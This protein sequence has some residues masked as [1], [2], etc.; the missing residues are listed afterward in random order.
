MSAA[1]FEQAPGAPFAR[2]VV[3]AP[4]V[5][6]ERLRSYRLG[7]LRA[8]MAEADVALCVLVNPVSLRYALDLREYAL[9][10]S[11]IPTIYAFVPVTGP[12]VLHGAAGRSYDTVDEYRTPRRLST[13]DGGL[14]LSDQAR[15]FAS[16]VK[17]L[18]REI[19]LGQ[20]RRVGVEMLNPSAGQALL[21]VG[22][23]TVDGESLVERARSIKAPEEIACQRH[24]IAVAEHAMS[25]MREALAPGIRETEL[26]SILHQVN[27]AHDGDWCDGRMLASGPRTNPWLQEASERVVRAGELVA[28]DTDMIGPL[29]YC[30]DISRT[31]LC[32]D[33]EATDIQRDRYRRARDEVEHNLALLRPGRSFRELSER[34]F[35]HPPEFVARRYPCLAHG[36]GM[37]DEWPKIHYREDWDRD[38]YDGVVEAG[39]TLCVESFVGSVHGGEGVK[40]EQMALVTG[41][42]AEALSTFPFEDRLLG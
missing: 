29:G 2:A 37:T 35:A 25:L 38:G 4:P 28:F 17:D 18:L 22:L 20:E 42:G 26:W 27:I 23:E 6:L 19:G 30:A 41:T 39:M 9:F 33:G 5:D 8:L 14:S 40:L 16:D 31:W 11:R 1:R 21:Q 3:E 13:F 32:G 24:A 7:R 34:A 10:Q 15:R 36:I 12:V